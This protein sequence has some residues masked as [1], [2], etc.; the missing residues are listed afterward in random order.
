[1]QILGIGILTWITFVPVLGMV[2]VLL[3]PKEQR[4][5]IRWTSLGFV[6]AQ[7]LFAVVAVMKFDIGLAALTLRPGCSLL[8]KRPGLISKV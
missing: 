4:N 5:A 1:M 7:L 2:L 8:K 3:I 6:G